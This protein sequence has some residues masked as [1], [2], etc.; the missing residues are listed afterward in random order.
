ME[1]TQVQLGHILKRFPDFELSYE[2]ISHNK[3]SPD[4]NIAL[5][6][7]TGKKAYIWF[8]FHQEQ[9]VCYL[10]DLNK[11]KKI[12]KATRLDACDSFEHKLAF[13]AVFYGTIIVDE[14]TGNHWFVIE[15]TFIYKGISLKRKQLS[16][17]LT[18][19]ADFM[20]N[21]TNTSN[22]LKSKD[23]KFVLPLMWTIDETM[24]VFSDTPCLPEHIQNTIGYTAHHM[25]YRS[26]SNIM[27]Y[28][29]V[30][31]NRKLNALSTNAST[32]SIVS[33]KSSH[34]F[35]TMAFTPDFNKPQYKYPTV[36]QVTADI[37]F[38]IYHLFAYGKNNKPVYYNVAY[39]PNCKSSTFMNVLF[40]KIRENKNLDYIEESDDEDD[41]QNMDEDKYVDINKVILMEFTFH[42][43]FKRWVPV[44]VADRQEKVVHMNKLIR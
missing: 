29:N 19:F 2:T 10:L 26:T 40:R 9:N 34:V 11:D 36:F 37:Q 6:I 5:A 1:L 18:I 27:P 12:T 35:E 31:L 21:S 32:V 43:K 14:M 30:F 16:D 42:K 25:Q 23:F 28:L 38:D 17:K 33:K 7:P 22:K 20:S 15:D 39:I 24:T 8:T 3:V 41:F 4:Y 13:G 44:R